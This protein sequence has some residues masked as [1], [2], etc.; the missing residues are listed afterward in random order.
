MTREQ[1]EAR[2]AVERQIEAQRDDRPPGSRWAAQSARTRAALRARS[3]RGLV[4][5]VLGLL[6][7]AV[8]PACLTFGYIQEQAVL[9]SHGVHAEAS[10]LAHHPSRFGS[11]TITVRPIEPPRFETT[12]DHWPAGVDVGDRIEVVY[13][14][15]DPGTA[16]AVDAPLV[17]IGIIIGALFDLFALALLLV[18]LLPLGELLRRA[19]IRLR[20]GRPGN[21]HLLQQRD[22]LGLRPTSRPAHPTRP[23]RRRPQLLASLETAQIVFFVGLAPVAV[24]IALGMFA[25]GAVDDARALQDTGARARATVV[26]SDWTVGGGGWLDV[27]FTLPDGTEATSFIRPQDHVYYEGNVVD[28]VYEPGRP[29]NAEAVGDSGWQADTRVFVGFSVALVAAAVVSVLTGTVALV[30]RARRPATDDAAPPAG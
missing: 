12:L 29:G 25:A 14:P 28:L 9:E 18:A 22:P 20:D 5:M 26:R 3:G 7:F 16:A 4:A 13:D 1:K 17:D 23:A 15:R 6:A 27:R 2:R 11:G 19:W 30:Q 21:E 8:F 24:A 10:V